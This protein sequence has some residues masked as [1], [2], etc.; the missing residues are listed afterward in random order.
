MHVR[1][2]WVSQLKR[3]TLQRQKVGFGHNKVRTDTIPSIWKQHERDRQIRREGQKNQH[4]P[5][6]RSFMW[7][8][9]AVM[10]AT[11][12]GGRAHAADPPRPQP[13]QWKDPLFTQP[14]IDTDEWHDKPVRH[15]YVHGGFKGTDTLF[16]IYFPPKEQYQGRFFQPVAAVSGNDRAAQQQAA[17]ANPNITNENTTIG[18]AIASG[19]YLVESN[20]GSKTMYPLPDPTIEGYRAS[21]AVAL[22][23]RRL[24]A[25]MYGPHR[26]YGYMYGGSGGGYKTISA[27]ENTVG[28]W[29]GAV[30]YVIG[31]PM[32][33]PY[34]FMVQAH[35]IR[36]LKD[37]LPAIIDTIDPGGSHD[38]YAGLNAEER[39][40]LLE[41]TRMGFPP[42]TWFAYERLG[43]GPLAVLIDYVIKWDPSYFEDFWKVPGYLG[44][45]RPESFARDRI[46]QKTTIT[47]IVMSDEA[48]KSGIPVPMAAVG[49]LVVPSAFQFANM[50]PGDLKGASIIFKSGAASGQRISISGQTGNLATIGIGADAFK[51]MDGVQV[52]DE[53]EIDNSIYLAVQTYYRHQVPGRDF[54]TW[55]QFRGPDGKPL[56]PQRSVLLGPK[57]AEQGSGSIQNGKFSGKMIV[58]ESLMDEYA[59]PWNADWYRNKV[60]EV[61][62]PKTDDNF[63]LWY[64][65]HAMHGSPGPQ[66]PDRARIVAYSNVLQQALR[67]VAAWVEKGTPPPPSTNYKV[68]DGQ[69]EVP[70]MAAE[71]KG[72]QPVVTLSVNGGMSTEAKVGQPVTFSGS[73][74]VPPGAGKVVEAEWG[75][76]GAGEYPVAGELKTTDASQARATVAATYS[77][78]K[79]GTYF[80]VLR[81][82][83]QRQPDGT[84][85]ARVP[86]LARVRVIVN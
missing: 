83:A 33:T 80:P 85:Y 47:K 45:D 72:I 58:V 19:A 13:A 39:A 53:V 63:R 73:I 9:L 82:A 75:F 1:K 50:P 74:E 25:A 42:R 55:N 84:P 24:A 37:K 41:A 18:F 38:M 29:D 62:G 56:Y 66:G 71:R 68:V 10:L 81:A 40:A 36:I 34:I 49:S 43:Y 6:R 21:A 28:I 61:L 86:N 78:T 54:Y 60:K 51:Y 3:T 44:A 12:V 16:S 30:P 31:S 77:F 35:A 48:R 32:A 2:C 70:A 11:S 79:P 17:Q 76:E 5:Q 15:R 59:V 46:Q 67:D 4:V 23:S 57:N 14:Y 26:P 7:A 20:L 69:V 22:Y 65:D 27:M 52:G 64:T 8:A